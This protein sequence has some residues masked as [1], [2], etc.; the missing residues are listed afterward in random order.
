[1]SREV[2]V[3]IIVLRKND[4]RGLMTLIHET[5]LRSTN[6]GFRRMCR[7]VVRQIR[8]AQS[9]VDDPEEGTTNS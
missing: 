3:A 4:M 7:S 8:R 6:E 5:G 2:D 9:N 1:M